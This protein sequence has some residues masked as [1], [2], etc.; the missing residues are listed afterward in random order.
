MLDYNSG[1]LAA[2]TCTLLLVITLTFPS[3]FS[4]TSHFREKG[5][6]IPNT[7]T[8]KD[9]VAT[10]ETIAAF[11][12]KIP[13]TLLMISTLLGFATSI[14][15]AVLDLFRYDGLKLEDWLNVALWASRIFHAFGQH[16]HTCIILLTWP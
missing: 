11:S 1:S 12:T 13:K 8:D 3:V 4:L 15:L 16:I 10:E 14:T 5:K 2:A 9:G 6:Q 7:Y